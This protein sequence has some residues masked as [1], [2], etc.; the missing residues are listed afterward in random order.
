[1]VGQGVMVLYSYLFDSTMTQHPAA[2]LDILNF[3]EFPTLKMLLYCFQ[4]VNLVT[5]YKKNSKKGV[6]E[7]YDYHGR[8][9]MSIT[10]QFGNSRDITWIC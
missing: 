10:A 3:Q 2:H 6:K 7:E 8:G 5:Y 9:E 4:L 1:M